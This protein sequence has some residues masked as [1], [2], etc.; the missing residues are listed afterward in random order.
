MSGQAAGRPAVI[1]LSAISAGMTAAPT[2]AR[3]MIAS[4]MLVPHLAVAA[5][6]SLTDIAS[7]WEPFAALAAIMGIGG[8]YAARRRRK[9]KAWPGA[10]PAM[11][12]PTAE[13]MEATKAEFARFVATLPALE[14]MDG[15]ADR[16]VEI[17]GYRVA[18]A[19]RPYLGEADLFRAN[20]HFTAHVDAV[21]D[22]KNPFLTRRKRLK[23]AQ[24]LDARL[25]EMKAVMVQNIVSPPDK[26]QT[27]RTLESAFS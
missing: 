6:A 4:G 16:K 8:A 7:D 19:P 25:A 21:P 11:A 13:D 18:A 12:Q 3:D 15:K 26:R 27:P 22:A 20:G 9:G 1:S 14:T 2:H 23:R 10:V 24:L 17:A 5:E